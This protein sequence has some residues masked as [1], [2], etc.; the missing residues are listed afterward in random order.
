MQW[1]CDSGSTNKL[2]FK[3]LLVRQEANEMIVNV[4]LCWPTFSAHNT[5]ADCIVFLASRMS[6]YE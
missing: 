6:H 3:Y 1:C 4:W 5:R 2:F